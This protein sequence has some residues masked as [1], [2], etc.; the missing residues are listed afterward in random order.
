MG[1]VA[2]D[3]LYITVC[4]ILVNN[5]KVKSKNSKKVSAL[6]DVLLFTFKF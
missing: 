6:R 1:S 2:G 5:S 4:C 3:N